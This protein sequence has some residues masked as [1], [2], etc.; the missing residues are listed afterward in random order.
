[1]DSINS[2]FIVKSL[3][4]IN[5]HVN[6]ACEYHDRIR[7]RLIPF[8]ELSSEEIKERA[9]ANLSLIAIN[10]AINNIEDEDE[11]HTCDQF[12]KTIS[13]LYR[14]PDRYLG[15]AIQIIREGNAA[16]PEFEPNEYKDGEEE[17]VILDNRDGGDNSGHDDRR[18]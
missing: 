9:S 13:T 16:F 11:K 17:Q 10:E 4:D 5:T 3:L 12:L 1:M 6:C 15:E 18:E 2:P 7:G 8:L 14:H